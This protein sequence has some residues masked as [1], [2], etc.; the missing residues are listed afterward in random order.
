[1]LPPTSSVRFNG[2]YIH[3]DILNGF[4]FTIKEFDHDYVSFT[5]YTEESSGYTQAETA[6]WEAKYRVKWS[7]DQVGAISKNQKQGVIPTIASAKDAIRDAIENSPLLPDLKQRLMTAIQSARPIVNGINQIFERGNPYKSAWYTDT[8]KLKFAIKKD[9]SQVSASK[10]P[11]RYVPKQWDPARFDKLGGV[12]VIDIQ[13]LAY[14][15]KED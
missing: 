14:P 1:M 8:G 12:D 10:V 7:N 15:N 4:S 13:F 6:Q 11:V 9:G 3:E 5:R 2:L